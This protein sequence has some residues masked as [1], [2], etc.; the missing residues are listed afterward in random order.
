M[1]VKHE[2]KK[3]TKTGSPY[4]CIVDCSINPNEEV[5]VFCL[6]NNEVIQ[7]ELNN[8]EGDAET[9]QKDSNSKSNTNTTITCDGSK[10]QS[11]VFK[12][13]PIGFHKDTVT[14]VDVC[15][16][17]SIVVTS[18]T[19]K[20][21]RVWNFLKKTVEI[22]KKF[23]E[24][25]LSIAIHPS[26]YTLVAG[27]RF[28]LCVFL[29]L[30]NDL[31]PCHEFTNIKQCREI[32]FS[33]GGQYFAAVG[34]PWSRIALFNSYT[35]LPLSSRENPSGAPLTGHSASVQSI[36]W[37]QNDQHLISAG[38]DGAIYHWVVSTGKRLEQNESV[39]K[40]VNYQCIRY[41]DDS[42]TLATIAV[43]RPATDSGYKEEK[44]GPSKQSNTDSEVTLRTLRFQL[45]YPPKAPQRVMQN[46]ITISS[47]GIQQHPSPAVVAGNNNQNS[48]STDQNNN[49]FYSKTTPQAGG[50]QPR[51][52]R[53]SQLA[54]SPLAQT[55]FVATSTGQILLYEWPP[56]DG[57]QPYTK[58]EVHAGEI[59]FI[60]LSL[61]E[62]F[63]SC[64]FLLFFS[65][66][67][68]K[69]KTQKKQKPPPDTYS[70]SDQKIVVYLHS[71]WIPS[72]REDL[73]QENHSRT[74]PLNMSHTLVN[75]NMM[76][77]EGTSLN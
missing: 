4:P 59:L 6:D 50:R 60:L 7:L 33:H 38:S 16:Q 58:M 71:K 72:L 35:F 15:V 40:Y 8:I 77:R 53:S 11:K 18:S 51:S 9:E 69:K 25:V 70:Q 13:I 47:Q 75:M 28:K 68:N 23:D 22:S 41:D 12:K 67:K 48:T 20:H 10:Q 43:H 29:V 52:L 54:I 5:A 1:L 2:K 63:V 31:Q 65:S 42:Q 62:K 21:I 55:L 64:F 44:P 66:Q 57:A 61:D 24:E 19:D 34:N 73:L 46:P 76:K 49:R 32:R 74:H 30:A 27:F 17:R 26:G 39:L 3:K 36:C 56:S 45:E 14:G 37:S